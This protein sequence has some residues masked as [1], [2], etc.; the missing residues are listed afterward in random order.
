MG[1]RVATGARDHTVKLWAP[2]QGG[3]GSHSSNSGVSLVKPIRTLRGHTGDVTSLATIRTTPAAA[4]GHDTSTSNSNVNINTNSFSVLASGSTDTTIKLWDISV[5][6][7]LPPAAAPAAHST[8]R[9]PSRSVRNVDAATG[10]AVGSRR[11]HQ[12][13]H[14]PLLA[15][16]RGHG[17]AVTCL[18]RWDE[19]AMSGGSSS[20]SRGT[21]SSLSTGCGLLSGSRDGRVKLWDVAEGRGACTATWRMP[22]AALRVVDGLFLPGCVTVMTSGALQVSLDDAGAVWRPV[23]PT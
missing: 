8:N 15:T 2:F 9:R 18:L 5:L 17:A 13:G 10:S 6:Q 11:L 20:S 3:S 1:F 12:R 16:L 7:Q 19:D 4:V 14:Q 21:S 23:G 22:S